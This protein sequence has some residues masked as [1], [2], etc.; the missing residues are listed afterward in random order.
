MVIFSLE[1]K[2][3]HITADFET[4]VFKLVDI[5]EIDTAKTI[6]KKSPE[7]AENVGE[8][9]LEIEESEEITKIT[10]ITDITEIAEIAK[11]A[12]VTEKETQ[13]EMSIRDYVQHNFNYIS[14]RIRDCLIYPALAKR[15][16]TQGTVVIVFT[17]LADGSIGNIGV[18]SSSGEETLDA[19]AINAVR[20]ASPFKAPNASV[21]LS[22]P[23]VFT[24]R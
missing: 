3:N 13:E 9:I 22:V 23:V 2:K 12:D 18:S 5:D 1:Y 7:K 15:T 6:T 8:R 16:G 10:D 14:R 17:I 19:A 21:R 11:I 24:L 4:K 20:T